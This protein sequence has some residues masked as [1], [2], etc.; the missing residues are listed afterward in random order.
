MI[1]INTARYEVFFPRA[2]RDYP[3]D[4]LENDIIHVL[5]KP[6]FV[7][8]EML[9]EREK[10][11]Q[12][13]FLVF[14]NDIS[15]ND[16]SDHH[17]FTDEISDIKN[18]NIPEISLIIIIEGKKKKK[19]LRELELLGIS[20]HFLFPEIENKCHAIEKQVENRFEA[21]TVD[22]DLK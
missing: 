13:A 21:S 14:P 8:P 2:Q 12:A 7:L 1:Y 22:E 11:Q 19:L 20:Q 10:R 5:D 6:M 16:S 4:V 15:E 18:R 3:L 9:S 17:Y